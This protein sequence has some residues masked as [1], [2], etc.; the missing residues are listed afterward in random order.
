MCTRSA[1]ELRGKYLRY[2][3]SSWWGSG[4]WCGTASRS[5]PKIDVIHHRGRLRITLLATLA[6][7][8]SGDG[9]LSQLRSLLPLGRAAQQS[10]LGRSGFTVYDLPTSTQP[11]EGRCNRPV[12]AAVAQSQSSSR[13]PTA[14]S[15][16]SPLSQPQPLSP[17]TPPDNLL[18]NT[19]PPE[20]PDTH[21]SYRHQVRL[22]GACAAAGLI[23][24][25]VKTPA[26]STA[27]D[28]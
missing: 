2:L 27:S 7:L 9:K 15:I 14:G 21:L 13:D 23:A 25:A 24:I 4:G 22:D 6:R 10:L 16:S 19:T 20:E 28:R 26:S 12:L 3:E 11:I 17:Y 8:G 5:S 1:E 18:D